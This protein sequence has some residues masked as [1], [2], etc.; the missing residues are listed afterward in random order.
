MLNKP[1]NF[2]CPTNRYSINPAA[3]GGPTEITNERNFKSE[4]GPRK[5][6]VILEQQ[7][8]IFQLLLAIVPQCP[9]NDKNAILWYGLSE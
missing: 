1:A 6:N 9:I 5:L 3:T 8:K 2:Q 4:I 7:L